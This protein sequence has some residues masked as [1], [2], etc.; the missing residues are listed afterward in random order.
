M[1]KARLILGKSGEEEAVTLLKSNGYRILARNYKTKLGEIDIIA[2]EQDT[3]CFV[4]VKARQSDKFGLPQEAV[5]HPK[6]K[7]ISRAALVFLKENRLLDKKARFDVVAVTF[8][9]GSTQTDLIK[10]AFD[11]DERYIY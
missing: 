11:L 4:E 3:I 9:Q 8:A 6:Q 5:S 2:R 7:H 1:S 10:N